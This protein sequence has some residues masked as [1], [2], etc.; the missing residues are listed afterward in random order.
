MCLYMYIL[1]TNSLTFSWNYIESYSDSTS[2]ILYAKVWKKFP[3]SMTINV[4]A[5]IFLC[6]STRW[7]FMHAWFHVMHALLLKNNIFLPLHQ[8]HVEKPPFYYMIP[9]LHI[10]EE[11]LQFWEKEMFSRNIHFRNF[12]VFFLRNEITIVLRNQIRLRNFCF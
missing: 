3:H 5:N 8:Q 4:R 1:S 9:F 10:W 11:S 6:P 7:I 12:K 2:Y